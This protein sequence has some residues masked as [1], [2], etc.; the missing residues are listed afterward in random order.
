MD[1]FHINEEGDNDNHNHNDNRNH[2]LNNHPNHNNGGHDTH[3]P[4]IPQERPLRDYGRPTLGGAASS[5]LCPIRGDQTYQTPVPLINLIQSRAF[6]GGPDED[7]NAHLRDF[8]RLAET[9]KARGVHVDDLKLSLFPFSLKGEAQEWLYEHPAGYFTTWD[10][11]ATEF[12][13]E[14]F[15]PPGPKH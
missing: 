3:I 13:E 4:L 15:S 2:L 10:G 12:L 6:A 14:F 1:E 5:I 7:P 11:L 9:N 8:V